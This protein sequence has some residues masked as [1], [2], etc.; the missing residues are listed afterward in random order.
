MDRSAD[1]PFGDVGADVITSNLASHDS[2]CFD[3]LRSSLAVAA[4]LDTLVDAT[5]HLQVYEAVD[6]SAVASPYLPILGA[7]SND[8][9]CR[10]CDR[11]SSGEEGYLVEVSWR[12]VGSV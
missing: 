2:D 9:G 5:T 6:A 11:L 7:W 3:K 8:D 1:E 12:N 10:A 4:L